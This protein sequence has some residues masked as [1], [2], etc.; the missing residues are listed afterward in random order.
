DD[1]FM[2]A[3]Q[4]PNLRWDFSARA[5]R[6]FNKPKLEDGETEVPVSN[7][8]ICCRLLAGSQDF[9][10]VLHETGRFA[11]AG[12]DMW[13]LRA[14]VTLPQLRNRLSKV[15]RKDEQM[16]IVNATKNRIAWF[17]LGPENDIAVRSVWDIDE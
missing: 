9:E 7:F 1:E 16:I 11:R 8:F 17:N 12:G 15:M 2:R 14:D 6:G 5:A 10:D 4:H 13:V 3:D